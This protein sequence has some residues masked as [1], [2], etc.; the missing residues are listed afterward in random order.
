M[1][2]GA[3]AVPFASTVSKPP[4]GRTEGNGVLAPPAPADAGPRSASPDLIKSVPGP[5]PRIPRLLVADDDRGVIA[6]YRLVF[7]EMPGIST[8]HNMVDL[9]TLESELFGVEPANPE[10]SAPLSWRVHFVD[11]G[12]DAVNE[13]QWA[14]ENGDPYAAIFLDVRMPPGIDGYETAERIRKIDPNVHIVIVTA[15]SDYTY[16]DFLEVA[17]PAERLTHMAK[18]LW[19][20]ELRNVARMLTSKKSL[21]QQ[22]RHDDFAE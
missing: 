20:E 21:L 5:A 7:G 6:S 4:S 17:G 19:P 10:T 15:F 1:S 16:E 8:S 12:L 3:Q 2:L 22:T 14:I 11:Q 18:P 9:G 13:V